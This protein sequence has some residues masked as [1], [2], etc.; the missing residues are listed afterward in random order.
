MV[1]PTID[2]VYQKLSPIERQ[3]AGMVKLG[4]PTKVIAATLNITAGTVNTHRKHIR[5][6]LGLDNKE[7]LQG[8]LQSLKDSN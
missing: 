8:Y 2:S 1:E 7:N 6:K 4:Q 5:K 3:V